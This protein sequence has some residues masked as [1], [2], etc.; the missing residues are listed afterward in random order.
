MMFLSNSKLGD[1]VKTQVKF[2]LNAYMGA[3]VSFIFIQLLGLLLSI[4]GSSSM[5]T[6]INNISIKVSVI[7]YDIVFIFVVIWALFVG[8]LITTKAYR[9]DDFSFVT[10]RLSNNLANIVVLCL[11]SV[12]AGVTTFLSTYLLRIIVLL[13]SNLDYDKGPGLLENPI[14]SLINVAVMIF[15]IL[16]I[17]AAGYLWGVLVQITKIFMILL[18]LLIVAMLATQF[19]QTF[20]QYIFIGNISMLVLMIKLICVSVLLFG[21]AILSSNRLEVRS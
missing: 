20:I 13:F 16:T 5:G 11:L 17:S 1:V 15:V 18:P 4:N 19:G 6:S 12:F 8:N 9:Y 7:S 14:S 21:V 3:V 2:K 10:T